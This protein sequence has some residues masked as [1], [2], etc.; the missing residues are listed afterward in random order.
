MTWS[1]QINHTLMCEWKNGANASRDQLDRSAR[2]ATGD[3]RSHAV[4]SSNAVANHDVVIVGLDENQLRLQI[5]LDAANSKFPLIVTT[6]QGLERV[7]QSFNEPKLESVFDPLVIDWSRVPTSYI[8]CDGESELWEIAEVVVPE[9][10]S[11]MQAGVMI[12][13][14]RDLAQ[15]ISSLWTHMGPQAKSA[16]ESKVNSTLSAMQQHGFSQYFKWDG[17][18]RKLMASTNLHS[19]TPTERSRMLQRLRS[20]QN[21]FVS[22][23]RAQVEPGH[24]ESGIQLSLDV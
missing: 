6:E 2:V 7:S 15:S 16:L 14:G 12:F 21:K 4:I 3:L 17:R 23:L 20:T 8:S 13:V 24:P 18:Q 9:I 19:V 11:E 5:S 22:T 10:L 1:E